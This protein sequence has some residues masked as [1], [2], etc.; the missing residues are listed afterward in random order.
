MLVDAG[1]G[2]DGAHEGGRVVGF[3]ETVSRA[4][5]NYFQLD[6]AVVLRHLL[7]FFQNLRRCSTHLNNIQTWRSR[8][9][10]GDEAQGRDR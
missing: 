2:E 5:V 8:P 7:H 10:P 4:A 3:G 1:V 9:T 6:R